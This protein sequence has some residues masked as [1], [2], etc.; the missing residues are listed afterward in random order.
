MHTAQGF[1]T[2]WLSCSNMVE[3]FI[4]SFFTTGPIRMFE[5]CNRHTQKY[6]E[7]RAPEVLHTANIYSLVISCCYLPY[8]VSVVRVGD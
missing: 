6:D 3:A 1:Y 5:Y 8:V 4:T 2:Y 7:V